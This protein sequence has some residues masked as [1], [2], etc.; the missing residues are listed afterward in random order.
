MQRFSKAQKTFGYVIPTDLQKKL[1]FN[2]DFIT[3]LPFQRI[4]I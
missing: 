1:D 2:C 4:V 3:E